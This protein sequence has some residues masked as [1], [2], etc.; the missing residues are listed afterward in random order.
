MCRRKPVRFDL[1]FS[2][3]N[4]HIDLDLFLIL[5]GRKKQQINKKDSK[6]ETRKISFPALKFSRKE[7]FLVKKLVGF[8]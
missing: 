3:S 8:F 7:R 6:K 4:S 5:F 2:L 1:T